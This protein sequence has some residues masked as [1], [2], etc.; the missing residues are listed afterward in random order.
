M[1]RF[2]ALLHKVSG[3]GVCFHRKNIKFAMTFI[4]KGKYTC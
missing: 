3:F 4:Y 1:A 2:N